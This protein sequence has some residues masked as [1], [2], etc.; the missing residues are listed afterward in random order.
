MA[1]FEAD[2]GK[3]MKLK[4]ILILGSTLAFLSGCATVKP[5]VK[6]EEP[7]VTLTL[8]GDVLLDHWP[9]RKIYQRIQDRKDPNVV[10]DYP[11]QKL[12]P[13]LQGIV[14]CNAEG[15][16]T[17]W[18]PQ[19]FADKDEKSYFSVSP[20][21]GK[22]MGRAGFHVVSLANNHVRD[23]GP[24]GVLQSIQV[25]KGNG[26]TPVGAGKDDVS[27]RQPVFIERNGLRVGFLSYDMVPPKSVWAKPAHPG[28][29]HS[30]LKGM[31]QDVKAAR[32]QCDLLVVN[33]HWGVEFRHQ[34]LVKP[35]SSS[36]VKIAHALIDAG[37]NLV[38]GEHSHSIERMERYKNGLIFY[39]MGNFVFGAATREG[40]PES[41]VLQ[42]DLTRKG[43]QDYRVIPILI[44]PQK[45]RY[46]PFPLEGEQ[47]ER[48]LKMFQAL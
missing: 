34:S 16:L 43:V 13:F 47:K 20:E 46:Q 35:P 27:A 3:E 24:K 12:K 45:T 8:G 30:E 29:A 26:M 28:A 39:G 32:A 25:L 1:T 42:V 48:F 15:P 40:H 37:V 44:S 31:L 5:P 23:C 33:F 38:V 6:T 2:R 19:P 41:M 7:M 17:D 36:R 14:F 10:L 11:F 22:S 9:I 21:F 4:D 18:G